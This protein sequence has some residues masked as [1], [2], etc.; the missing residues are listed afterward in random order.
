MPKFALVLSSV[1]AM[2]AL[3]LGAA[4]ALA[5]QVRTWVSGT[6]DDLNPCTRTAPCK[7][8][9]G[10]ISRTAPGGVIHVLDPGGFGAV[11]ITKA[12]SIVTDSNVGAITALGTTGIIV[13]AA[14]GDVMHLDG[15]TIDGGVS[16][17][18]GIRFLAGG[19]LHVRNCVIRGFRGTPG[20]GISLE[21]TAAG[22]SRLYV[23]DSTVSNNTGG[24]L[25]KSSSAASATAMLKGV[26]VVR[27]ATFGI[28]ADGAT[29][30]ARPRS[31]P[32]FRART[33]SP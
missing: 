16:G 30:V 3:L 5:Q 24:I 2:L 19:E 21:P 13:N 1:A 33:R 29:A 32:N 7:T 20:V 25:V 17:I 14:P 18:N 15:L 10:A 8:F 4:P 31:M 22:N 12:L 28:R 9:G 26:H 23:E 11:T 6:G 27:N